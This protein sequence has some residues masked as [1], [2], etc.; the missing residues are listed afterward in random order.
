VAGTVL[1]GELGLD[2]RV[3]PVR[4]VLPATMAAT[5]AGFGRVVMPVDRHPK[6]VGEGIEVYFSVDRQTSRILSVTFRH[7][8]R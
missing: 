6:P 7:P 2:G 3:R 1:L 4:G 8:P 5:S